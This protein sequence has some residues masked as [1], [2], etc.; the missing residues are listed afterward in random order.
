MTSRPV[1]FARNLVAVAGLLYAG[2]I[3]LGTVLHELYTRRL[4]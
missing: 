3:A 4:P 2:G 1:R